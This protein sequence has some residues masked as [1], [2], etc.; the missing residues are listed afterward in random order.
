MCEYEVN[1]LTNEK[2]ITDI[3]IDI[4]S[5]CMSRQ[6]NIGVLFC[7]VLG[8][9]VFMKR[10]LMLT[11]KLFCTSDPKL[12]TNQMSICLA[13]CVFLYACLINTHI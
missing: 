6:I 10:Q 8:V 1:P 13:K 9:T 12:S 5:M 7:F 4:A 11:V 2:V 3:Q